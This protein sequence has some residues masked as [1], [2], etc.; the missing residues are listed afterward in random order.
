MPNNAEI[1]WDKVLA[2]IKR[3]GLHRLPIW[4]KCNISPVY[5]HRIKKGEMEPPKDLAFLLGKALG[6]KV[7]AFRKTKPKKDDEEGS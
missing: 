1:D 7:E 3:K 4:R 2:I 5:I 6:V